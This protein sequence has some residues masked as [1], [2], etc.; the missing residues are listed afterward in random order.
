M[1]SNDSVG[2]DASV[3]AAEKKGTIAPER[4]ASVH[5]QD[6]PGDLHNSFDDEPWATRNGLNLDSF[7]CRHYGLGYQEMDRAM[8]GRHLNMIAI[9][10]S[11]GVFSSWILSSCDR[12]ES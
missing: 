9:G 7:R 5:G 3:G 2:H 12:C 11:I 10:G 1:S 6:G 8:K 4:A